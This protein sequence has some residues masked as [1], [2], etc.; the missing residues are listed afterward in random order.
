M[1]AIKK[2]QIIVRIPPGLKKQLERLANKKE[3]NISE[4][5]R[6]LIMNAINEENKS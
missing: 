6:L 5:V 3:M 1:A 4:Y 2:E